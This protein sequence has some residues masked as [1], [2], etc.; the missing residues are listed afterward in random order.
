[1]GASSLQ[2][3]SGRP[4]RVPAMKRSEFSTTSAWGAG[5]PASRRPVRSGIRAARCEP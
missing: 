5:P 1:L 3:A 2:P 4:R